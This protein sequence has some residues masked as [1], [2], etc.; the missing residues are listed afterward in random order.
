[1]CGSC[2]EGITGKSRPCFVFH[3]QHTADPQVSTQGTGIE[4]VAT[5][6]KLSFLFLDIRNRQTAAAQLKARLFGLYRF[7]LSLASSCRKLNVHLR[8]LSTNSLA[9]VDI[10]VDLSN[11]VSQIL[12]SANHEGAGGRLARQ[13]LQ[14]VQSIKL[15]AVLKRVLERSVCK[16]EANFIARS[17]IFVVEVFAV[18]VIILG[19][20]DRR[21][22]IDLVRLAVGLLLGKGVNEL[23]GGDHVTVGVTVGLAERSVTFWHVAHWSSRWR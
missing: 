19:E 6:H 1:M 9:R 5:V 3:S 4:T 14:F 20:V 2:E 8:N 18:E 10:S 21:L 15:I 11:D 12:A 16:T 7:D 23:A 17:I 13:Y 22:L